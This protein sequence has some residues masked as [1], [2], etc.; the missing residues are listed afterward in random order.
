VTLRS[1][2][3]LLFGFVALAVSVV[4]GASAYRATSSEVAATTDDFLQA[5]AA[6]IVGGARETPRDRRS[7]RNN[8]GDTVLDLAFDPDAIVQTVTANGI[9][10][11]TSSRSLP[12]TDATQRMIELRVDNDRRQVGIFED[13]TI[14][15]EP[16]RMFTQTLPIGGVLQ[17][18]R[19]TAED[20]S[21]LRS[22][23]TRFGLIAAAATVGASLLGWWIARRT[24]EPLRRL[25]DVAATVAE[26]R[27]FSVDVPVER[28]DEIG[29]LA[30]S[31][32]TM[33]TAL[34]TSRRQQHSLVQDASHEL[35]TPLT[36]LRAN[37]ALLERIENAQGQLA[38]GD[39]AAVLTAI[40]AEVSELGSLFNEL[41]DLAA[42]S[43][44]RDAPLVPLR[45]DEVVE[46]AVR[47]WEQRTDRVIEL[48][49]EPILINGNEAMLERAVTNLIG[50]AHKF[51]SP[52]EPVEVVV[53]SLGAGVGQ[54]FGGRTVGVSVRD[55]GPGIPAGDRVR[56]F[57]R[58]HRAETTRTMPGS[59]LGLAIVAQIVEHH[60]GEVWATES[61]RGGADVGFRLAV[62]GD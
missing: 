4:V 56:V 31:L 54:G 53:E 37:V 12:I 40:S 8:G 1:R 30:T 50:N 24:T 29:T 13:V 3:V 9:V 21:L 52:E 60:G 18:A 58:F 35:R 28:S 47:R 61:D 33:L 32:R 10:R 43:D 17:V 46:R 55:G 57:D 27:D 51:S 22:L 38:P 41:I 2:L 11:G 42:D 5:R 44:D 48:R 39:R 25:A 6:D 7:Q 20:D 45:L 59:G 23:L 15:G 14:D 16:F 34:E 26:T 49:T 19:S 36:S 62:V